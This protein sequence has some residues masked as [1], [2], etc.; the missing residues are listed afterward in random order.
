MIYLRRHDSLTSPKSCTIVN[1]P[2]LLATAYSLQFTL[3]LGFD[4]TSSIK[5]QQSTSYNQCE[6]TIF[7]NFTT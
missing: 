2:K 1:E 5:F 4:L 7:I 3:L 6:H